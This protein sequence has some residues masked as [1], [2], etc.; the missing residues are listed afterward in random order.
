[1]RKEILQSKWYVG[2]LAFDASA[3]LATPRNSLKLHGIYTRESLA[4]EASQSL[5][6]EDVVRVLNRLKE[7]RGVP[8]LL[9]CDNGS[10]FTGQMLDL[11]AYRNSVKIDFS[12]PGEPT[13]NALVESFNGTFRSEC[14]DANWFQNLTEAKQIIEA[15]RRE[16]TGHSPTGHQRSSLARSG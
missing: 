2:W 7:H 3:P 16:Y 10:R 1:L 4:I 11:W 6:G 5:K 12:R 14:L 13:D 15:W 9:F 8:K